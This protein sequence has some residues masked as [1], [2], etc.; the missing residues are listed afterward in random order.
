MNHEFENPP[1]KIIKNNSV[2]NNLTV[3]RYDIQFGAQT[4]PH[5]TQSTTTPKPK[6]H[7]KNVAKLERKSLKKKV[8]RCRVTKRSQ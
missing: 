5:S 3:T 8:H 4:Y 1:F 6:L 7:S 2:G